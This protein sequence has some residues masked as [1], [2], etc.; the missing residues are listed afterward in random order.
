MCRI[1]EVYWAAKRILALLDKV[2]L[3]EAGEKP[4][5]QVNGKGIGTLEAPRGI[6]VHSYLI[7]KGY[8]EKLRLL[9]ATQFNNAYINLLITDLA[10]KHLDGGAI[11]PTGE[12][13]IGRCVRLLDPCLSCATH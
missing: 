3:S 8:I 10:Q 7:N 4:D 9:V 12:Q 2:D 1:L 13:L 5:F 6:L 11:S